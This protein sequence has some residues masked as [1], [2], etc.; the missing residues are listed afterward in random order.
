MGALREEL[1]ELLGPQALRAL[2]KARGGRRAYIPKRPR[3]LHW[4][5][6]AVGREAADRL[7]WRYGACRIEVPRLSRYREERDERIRRLRAQGW[8]LVD[9]AED[10]ELSERQVRRIASRRAQPAGRRRVG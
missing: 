7:A 1:A 10:C 2:S 3:D 8:T 6:L 5:T 4:L 9:I